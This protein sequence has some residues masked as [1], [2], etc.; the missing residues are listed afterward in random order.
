MQSALR[1]PA[2]EIRTYIERYDYETDLK[3]A[4]IREAAKNQCYITRSQLHE[5]AR[6][7]SGRR[8]R[9]VNENDESF[10]REVTKFAFRANHEYSRIGALVLLASVHYPTASVILHF[11]VEES[12]PI[13]DFRAIW[14][15]GLTQ[16][17]VY[18]PKYWVEYT[19]ICRSLAKEHGLSVREFDMALW[20]YS[21]E[22][23][24][25]A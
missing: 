19:N 12:Y 11:C 6:W 10:V 15:L 25:D 16:P 22:H 14:S 13:L 7:K 3:L 17:S 18:T 23:Q 1:I 8:A 21:R 4:H 5:V 24:G 9:L 2:K 20:Q